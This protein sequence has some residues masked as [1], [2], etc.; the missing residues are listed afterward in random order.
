MEAI[1]RRTND[2]FSANNGT[3]HEWEA[4]FYCIFSGIN[5]I[6]TVHGFCHKS[7]IF[8]LSLI[9]IIYNIK[10]DMCVEPR[11]KEEE[12]I[13]MIWTTERSERSEPFMSILCFQEIYFSVSFPR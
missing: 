6:Q 8:D 4:N 1:S 2:Y 11:I 10:K 7:C 12:M 13:Q 3:A 5:T 9:H